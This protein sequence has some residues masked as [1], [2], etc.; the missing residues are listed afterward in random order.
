MSFVPRRYALSAM[1]PS[2]V[3]SAVGTNQMPVSPRNV[4]VAGRV[5]SVDVED[6]EAGGVA[7]GA[8]ATPAQSAQPTTGA[9]RRREVVV[10]VYLPRY[11][12]LWSRGVPRWRGVGCAQLSRDCSAGALRST[13]RPRYWSRF[14]WRLRGL[15]THAMMMLRK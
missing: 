5:S 15:T 1:R 10:T 4:V 9:N 12:L 11:T 13:A 8:P 3:T 7:V 6:G 2:G 14:S